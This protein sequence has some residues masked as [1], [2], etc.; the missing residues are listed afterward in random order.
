V[1]VTGVSLDSRTICPGDLYAALPGASSH[2]MD[3]VDEAA[4]NGA[5]AV[6]SD[7]TAEGRNSLPLLM[8]DDPRAVAGLVAAE[9]YGQPSQQLLMLGVTG[10]NGKTTVSYLLDAGLRA[11]GR[12]TGV[13]GT[14]GTVLADQTLAAVRTTPEATDLHAL[15]AVAVQRGV[16][17]VSMEV[18][19]HA[20]AQHRV[21]G[22]RYEAAIFTGLSQDHLDYHGTMDRYFAAK[23]KLFDPTRCGTA[24]ICLDDE[25]GDRLVER[26]RLPHVTYSAVG[27]P[28]A[29]WQVNDVVAD[30]RG[31]T[32]TAY[33]P[34][35]ERV[36]M[37]VGLPGM[38]N[39]A[40]ALGALAALVSVG[41][42]ASTAAAGIA[43]A[44]GVPGRLERVEAG[45]PYAALVDYA[46]TPDAVARVLQALRPLTSGRLVIVL[47]AGGD[48]D[49]GKRPA[50][51]RAAVEGA[52]LAVF[53]SDNPRS[54]DPLAILEQIT[55]G[56]TGVYVVEPDRRAAI[57]LAVRGL[58]PGDTVVLA[59]KGHETG[60]EI[61]GIVHPFDDR[62]V[63]LE[64]IGASVC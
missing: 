41:I 14:V 7:K 29:D 45:Q 43:V 57:A 20:L 5:V 8:S 37:S 52:D 60:Q 42:D 56:L 23:V 26:V 16:D 12:T 55:A 35:G 48:R 31:S 59:G 1:E 54:E 46:H 27:E 6:L 18:S 38:F 4:S 17:A 30:A 24:V 2:G 19:S 34:A 13:I 22:V 63:L 44:A 49:M 9:I 3:F 47:G 51:G 62:D 39:V 53:T 36:A 21:D 58:G 32:F 25:W 10:T 33:G 50:M 15:L 61:A 64:A 40:N 11:T 28:Q